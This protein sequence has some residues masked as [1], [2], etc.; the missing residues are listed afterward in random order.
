MEPTDE[1]ENDT[2]LS[3][4]WVELYDLSGNRIWRWSNTGEMERIEC[5]DS[6]ISLDLTEFRYLHHANGMVE[7]HPSIFKVALSYGGTLIEKKRLEGTKGIFFEAEDIHG[8][9]VAR[10][11]SASEM[12]QFGNESVQFGV[13]I[14]RPFKLEVQGPTSWEVDF[15]STSMNSN[16]YT[17]SL[18]WSPDGH[19]LAVSVYDMTKVY[20]TNGNEIRS[21][22]GKTGKVIWDGNCLLNLGVGDHSKAKYSISYPYIAAIGYY[23]KWCPSTDDYMYSINAENGV[24]F[25]FRAHYLRDWR[26][27]LQLVSGYSNSRVDRDSLSQLKIKE[28]NDPNLA[29]V[30]AGGPKVNKLPFKIPGITF[31]KDYMN[32]NGTI[33]TSKWG[34]K[35]YAI[36]YTWDTF[37]WVAGTHRFGTKAGLLWLQK[38][39]GP[40]RWAIVRW[41]DLNGNN[42]VESNE[43]ALISS[44]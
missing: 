30:V 16:K 7:T 19:Y 31:G 35:D 26:N 1:M 14:I 8:S 34:K 25:A 38:E 13:A 9:Y 2:L 24:I 6:K 39:A 4:G 27:S 37:V 20:D 41:E 28:A 11:Y 21:F 33:Y 29:L 15:S 12:E 17:A 18:A 23:A 3:S 36:I 42:D 10:I 22:G 5:E 32:V 40:Q 43:I 44:G